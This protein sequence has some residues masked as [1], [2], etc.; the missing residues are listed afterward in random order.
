MVYPSHF[1]GPCV[2]KVDMTP[3]VSGVPS[4][5]REDKIRRGDATLVKRVLGGCP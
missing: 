4:A 3:A 5:E 1:G 2:G